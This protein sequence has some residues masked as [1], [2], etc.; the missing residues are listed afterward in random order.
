M[1]INVC[2]NAVSMAKI[3]S[4]ISPLGFERELLKVEFTRIT[5]KKK[6]FDHIPSWGVDTETVSVY[7]LLVLR[8]PSLRFLSPPKHKGDKWNDICSV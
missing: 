3:A 6:V 5:K 1:I 2:I 8:Y 4:P 7:Y